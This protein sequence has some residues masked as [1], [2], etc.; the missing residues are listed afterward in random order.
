MIN[1]DV[2]QEGISKSQYEVSP[3]GAIKFMDSGDCPH[4]NPDTFDYNQR[5]QS[6]VASY[7]CAS[8][9]SFIKEK[10][11]LVHRIFEVQMS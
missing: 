1:T 10:K 8:L 11:N 6:N 7:L 3:Y 4:M 2:L 9:C 5:L